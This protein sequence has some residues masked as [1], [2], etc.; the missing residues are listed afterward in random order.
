MTLIK[1]QNTFVYASMALCIIAEF[2]SIVILN[3]Y[4]QLASIAQVIPLYLYMLI[5]IIFSTRQFYKFSKST[6][7]KNNL[8]VASLS[9]FCK[10][11]IHFIYLAFL[12]SN[13]LFVYSFFRCIDD[14]NTT[15][16]KAT[17][18]QLSIMIKKFIFN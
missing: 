4:N 16:G 2:L 8:N 1:I 9:N 7:I 13:L 6:R 17:C 10:V 14:T 15:D 18:K 12:T 11:T 5:F 3:E